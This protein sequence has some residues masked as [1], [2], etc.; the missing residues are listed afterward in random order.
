LILLFVKKSDGEGEDYYCIGEVEIIPGSMKQGNVPV[1]NE[2]V[3]H[4][5]YRFQHQVEDALYGYLVE[6]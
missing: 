3:V 1:T 6:E 4:F 2:P 5:T